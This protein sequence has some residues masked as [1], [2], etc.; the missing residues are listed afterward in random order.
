MVRLTLPLLLL[1]LCAVAPAEAKLS[2][3]V[4]VVDPGHGGK[5]EGVIAGG[6]TE[7]KLVLEIAL[8][9]KRCLSEN[10]GVVPVLTRESDEFV[11]LTD[12]IL[13]AE[14]AGGKVFLSL[15]LDKVWRG[16]ARGVI[17]FVYGRNDRI[18]KGPAREPGEKILPPPPMFQ[19][20]R[21]KK[22][23][24]KI[25]FS[26]KRADLKTVDYVDQGSFA[27]LKSGDMPSVLVELGNLHN[28]QERTLLMSAEYQERLAR[29]LADGIGR[30]IGME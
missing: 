10:D 6:I 29:S 26:V 21:A 9:L 22:L 1:S 18:P 24:E 19:I 13:K 4:V 28:E 27:V 17:P 12:R 2:E 25:R 20:M 15:H 5:D 23:A 30:F 11:T 16:R 14:K 3:R 8:R 7:K